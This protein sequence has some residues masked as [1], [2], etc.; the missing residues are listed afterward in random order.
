MKVVTLQSK[1][2]P[3]YQQNLAYLTE[4]IEKSEAELIVAPELCLTNF[5]YEHF[6][7]AAA[8]Y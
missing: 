4:F 1:T 6:E 3:T 7:S 5:D 8:F 2:L